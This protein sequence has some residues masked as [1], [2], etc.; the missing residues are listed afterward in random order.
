VGEVELEGRVLVMKRIH[1]IYHLRLDPEKREAALRA[2]SF[3]A[4]NCPMA[5]SVKGCIAI[6]TDLQMED[7]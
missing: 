1:V 5:R 6:T 4:D 3:H 2:H 7:L